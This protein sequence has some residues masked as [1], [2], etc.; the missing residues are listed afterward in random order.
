[1]ARKP[2][3][4]VVADAALLAASALLVALMTYW[5]K[6]RELRAQYLTTVVQLLTSE[7]ALAPGG[8]IHNVRTNIEQVRLVL[9]QQEGAGAAPLASLEGLAK[10]QELLEKFMAALRSAREEAEAAHAAAVAKMNAQHAQSAPAPGPSLLSALDAGVDDDELDDDDEFVEANERAVR[11]AVRHVMYAHG[12]AP[13]PRAACVRRLVAAL[14]QFVETV[15]GA[16]LVEH[17]GSLDVK[18]SNTSLRRRFPRQ[19]DE[20]KQMEKMRK[21]EREASNDVEDEELLDD[22]GP[23]DAAADDGATTTVSIDMRAFQD[24]RTRQMSVVDY[25]D[26]AA[27]RQKATFGTP[28]FARWGSAALR[29]AAPRKGD[30]NHPLRFFGRVATEWLSRW[31]EAA[32]RKAHGGALQVPGAP[33]AIEHYDGCEPS[34]AELSTYSAAAS[35]RPTPPPQPLAV[36]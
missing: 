29:L 1:M 9:E 31:V 25:D 3:V 8:A 15:G 20:L 23:G 11:Q 17:G 24:R 33:L 6:Q 14:T 21:V 7:P 36:R 16:A 22:D 30:K 26:F 18:A 12:D 13:R 4:S 28:Q 10:V 27:T 2:L 5:Q 32:N 35:S 34:V 19:W